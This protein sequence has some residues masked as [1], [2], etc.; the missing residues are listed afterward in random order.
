ME[1]SRTVLIVDDEPP[2]LR[3]LRAALETAGFAVAEAASGR[4]ALDLAA[5]RKPDVILLDL[6]LP[7]MDGLEVIGR[8]REW[9]AAPIIVVTV[10]GSESDKIAGLDRG[11]DDYLTKPFGVPELLA[12]IR[13]A[14][15][16]AQRRREDPEPVYR[17]GELVIDLAA[18]RVWQRKKE[19]RLSPLQYALLSAL[20]RNAGRVVAQR[21]LLQELWPEGGS[22]PEALRILVHQTR[23]RIEPEPARPRFLKTEPAVGYRL[24]VPDDE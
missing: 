8:L 16:H 14:L 19:L 23:H 17:R 1:G 2:I 10:R 24:E 12:R 4:R 20:V 11:A 15:R 22:S 5:L 21:K 7:D 18:H 6:G 3:F 13:V 9:T